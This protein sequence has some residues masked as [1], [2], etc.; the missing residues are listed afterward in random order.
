MARIIVLHD[1][2]GQQWVVSLPTA[3]LDQELPISRKQPIAGLNRQPI[4]PAEARS[5]P[6]GRASAVQDGNRICSPV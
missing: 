4:F 2:A 6:R 3:D 1:S 5:E